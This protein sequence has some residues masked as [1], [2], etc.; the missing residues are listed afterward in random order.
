MAAY[1][2]FGT[3]TPDTKYGATGLGQS[4]NYATAQK[5]TCGGSGTQEVSEI[6]MYAH[7]NDGTP[8]VLMAVFTHDAA[9]DCPETIVANSEIAVSP[10]GHDYVKVSASYSTKPQVTG[11]STYWLAMIVNGETYVAAEAAAGELELSASYP[12]W[13]TGTGWET[14]SHYNYDLSFYAVY[15]AVGGT[16]YP[17]SVIL[18]QYRPADWCVR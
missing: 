4:A 16:K 1:N 15:A 7:G 10:T 13:P 12:T 11:G 8:S 6:G 9:N 14:H 5:F 3:I 2:G 18:R 17:V